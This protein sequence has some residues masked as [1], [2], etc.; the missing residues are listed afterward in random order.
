MCAGNRVRLKI[1]VCFAHC[2]LR[3]LRCSYNGD[4]L[5]WWPAARDRLDQGSCM[6]RATKYQKSHFQ[7]QFSWY[8]TWWDRVAQSRWPKVPNSMLAAMQSISYTMERSGKGVWRLSFLNFDSL[9]TMAVE[10]CRVPAWQMNP[11]LFLSCQVLP[12]ASSRTKL[13]LH[14]CHCNINSHISSCGTLSS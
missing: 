9:R 11:A 10:R 8:T 14:G 3:L 5:P 1:E 7:M 2:W 13:T 6:C 12:H 4:H